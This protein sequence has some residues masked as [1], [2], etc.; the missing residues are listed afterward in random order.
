MIAL[1]VVLYVLAMFTG[2]GLNLFGLAGN[3]M[4]FSASIG[5]FLL[6]EGSHRLAI[7]LK[8]VVV[9]GVLALMGEVLETMASMLGAGKSGSSRRGMILSVLGALIGSVFGFSVGNLVVPIVGGVFGIV[10]LSGVGAL[11]GA[12]LGET[13]KGRSWQESLSIGKGAM[14]GRILGSLAKSFVAAVMLTLGILALC[15]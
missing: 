14:V 11:L 5:Y 12:L 9:L 8:L 2:V 13:W 1:W 15:V 3:W 10:L 7:S 6:V 4:M